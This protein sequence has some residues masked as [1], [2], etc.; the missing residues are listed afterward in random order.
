MDMEGRK[1]GSI[2]G[3]V[4]VLSWNLGGVNEE[5]MKNLSQ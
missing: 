1:E 4:K 3:L 2:C 5:I